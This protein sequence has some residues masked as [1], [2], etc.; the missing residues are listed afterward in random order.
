MRRLSL[1]LILIFACYI[2]S[3]RPLFAQNK[4]IFGLHLTQASDIVKTASIINSQG[5]DW[6]WATI[7]IRLDQLDHNTWQGFFDNCRKLHIIPI[8][9]LATINDNGVWKRPTFS[10]IDTLANFLN[11]LNWPTADQHIILFN[12]INRGQEWGGSVDIPSYVDNALYASNKFKNLNQNFIIL[13]AGLDLAAPQKMPDF[14][15]APDVYNQIIKY[16]ANFFDSI[17]AISSH[18][19]PNHGFIGTPSDTGQHSIVG[20]QWELSTLKNLGVTKKLPVYITET[21]WPHREGESK[22]NTFYTM[23][24][25][26]NMLLTAYK[27]WQ[28]DDQVIAVT[29]F[30]YNYPYEP[31]DH[32]SWVDKSETLYPAYQKVIDIPKAAN[33]P[34]QTF[35]AESVKINLPLFMFP[36]SEYSGEII[37]KNTGQSIWGKNE[38]EFCLS[39]DSTPNISL[40]AICSSNQTVEPGQTATFPFK[41]KISEPQEKN[42]ISWQ[43]LPVFKIVS[44]LPMITNAQI[45][46]PENGIIDRI[47][48]LYLNLFRQ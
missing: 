13:S 14:A 39:P 45:Y 48:R 25:T 9:R 18:S 11:S 4:N 2:G 30:I 19:Y 44:A 1:L 40:D 12:E 7:V 21:G 47:K 24:T 22:N 15:S 20:Y 27:K 8:V 23:E 33:K 42:F 31:F 38:H 6:G 36:N 37:L 16:K 46:R 17:D 3:T 41:F 29:P 26:S 35:K 5:G 43:S 10:D 28:A 34:I 32:F